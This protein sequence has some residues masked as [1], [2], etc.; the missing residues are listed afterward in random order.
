MSQKMLYSLVAFWPVLRGYGSGT[1]SALI[2]S[3]LPLL[4]VIFYR[5]SPRV[6]KLLIA[7]GIASTP[8]VFFLMAAIVGSRNS[9]EL[10][11]SKGSTVSYVGNEMLQ[12]LAFFIDNIPQRC[13]YQWGYNYYVQLVNPIP[14]F[15]WND[16][17]T[18]DSGILLA[19][20]K[21]NA[22]K[23]GEASMTDSPGLIGEMYLNF[24]V[25][26]IAGL[27]LIGGW[28]VKGWDE[29]QKRHAGS[30]P[31]MVFYCIGLAVLF[32]SGRSFNATAL[33]AIL[34]FYLA[35]AIVARF[36]SSRY[37]RESDPI[38]LN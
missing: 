4:A 18:L 32:M 35:V 26:G 8:F 33:Y 15:L 31:T 24:G 3:V 12:E 19:E 36:S 11:L 20:L 21:G 38:H 29:I 17:P 34:F 13:E 10:D 37:V 28:I 30:L 1:R 25:F 2:T 23:T 6:Q 16:K 27:S 22:D 5:S 7:A 9:G 14:R